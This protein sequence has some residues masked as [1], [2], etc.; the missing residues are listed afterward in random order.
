M[1][2]NRRGTPAQLPTQSACHACGEAVNLHHDNM[3]VELVEDPRSFNTNIIV[4]HQDC[5]DQF[6]DEGEVS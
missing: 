5:Y 2:R 1:S 6:L 3:M 4:W